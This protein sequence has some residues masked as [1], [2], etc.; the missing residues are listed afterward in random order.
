V[1]RAARVTAWIGLVGAALLAFGVLRLVQRLRHP[2]AGGRPEL[3]GRELF[4]HASE[5]IYLIDAAGRV[6]LANAQAGRDLG[7]APAELIDV[8][9]AELG[10]ELARGAPGGAYASP[11]QLRRKDGSLLPAELRSVP[12]TWQGESGQLLFA[13]TDAERHAREALRAAQDGEL[14][15]VRRFEA[16]GRMAGGIAHEF[17]NLLVV[18]AGLADLALERSLEQAATR[19]DLEEI[20]AAA[21]RASRLTRELL[22]FAR[23]Q[24]VEV[25]PVALNEVLVDLEAL[26][27]RL[28]GTNIGLRLELADSLGS[29]SV[30]PSQLEQAVVDLVLSARDATLPDGGEV[31]VTTRVIEAPVAGEATLR[32]GRY[33]ALRV[34]DH[35]AGLDPEA[36]ARLFE[37][38]VTRASEAG[39]SAL[40]LAFVRCFAEQAGGEVRVQSEPGK[41]TRVEL[42]LPLAAP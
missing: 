4:D 36:R 15:E 33:A 17:N 11:A 10:V 28:L 24:S 5:G 22:S 12:I 25:R 41:G 30:D 38:Y 19:R 32:A 39:G 34:I 35:G 26:L 40:G 18:I 29:V 9:L 6:S 42:L 13:R 14:R 31:L 2:H 3:P 20:R 27:D 8:P 1:G 37:P 7:R 21:E 16:V 23:S